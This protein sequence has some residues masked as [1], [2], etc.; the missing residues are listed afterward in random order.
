MCVLHYFLTNNTQ[1]RFSI[2]KYSND[3]HAIA[4]HFITFTAKTCNTKH[5]AKRPHFRRIAQVR[6]NIPSRKYPRKR[7]FC[8]QLLWGCYPDYYNLNLFNLRFSTFFYKHFL[9]FLNTLT[10]VVPGPCE[11]FR[12]KLLILFIGIWKPLIFLFNDG[13]YIFRRW[14]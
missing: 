6:C 13:S 1:H 12:T 2:G 14:T 9:L 4:Q 7:I 5:A 11:H 10:W 3:L 8:K